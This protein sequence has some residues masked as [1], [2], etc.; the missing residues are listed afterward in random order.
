MKLRD[1]DE[2][3]VYITI[4][5]PQKAE[6]RE[7]FTVYNTTPQRLREIIEAAIEESQREERTSASA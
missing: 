1:P 4:V 5:D 6:K 3:R 2:K 7:S